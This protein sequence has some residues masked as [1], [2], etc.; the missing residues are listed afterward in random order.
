MRTGSWRRRAGAARAAH[1][2]AVVGQEPSRGHAQVDHAAVL[3]AL[4]YPDRIGRRRPGSEGRFQ[5]ANGKGAVFEGSDSVARQEF[6]VAV[7]LDDRDREA[8]V[9]LAIPLDKAGFARHVCDDEIERGDELVW[10]ERSGSRD[11][12]P[13]NPPG[14]DSSSR[15][16]RCPMCRAMPAPRPC[17]RACAR[18]VSTRFPGMTSRVTLLARGR[19]RA[20]AGA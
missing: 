7:D 9:R 20:R 2:P 4:A 10:D 13:G 15:K 16:S 17:S 8:R 14:L 12:P 6:I 19:V 5:L 3:L 18:W 11:R 1:V